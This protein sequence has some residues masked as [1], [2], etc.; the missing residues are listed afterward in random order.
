MTEGTGVQPVKKRARP[1]ARL[2][3]GLAMGLFLGVFATL[4]VL[5]I[6]VDVLTSPRNIQMLVVPTT[7]TALEGDRRIIGIVEERSGLFRRH[8]GYY[9]YAGCEEDMGYG[10]FVDL[11]FGIPSP[12][13]IKDA[14]AESG[15]IRVRFDS[16]HELVIPPKSLNCWR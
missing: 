10:H 6:D 3:L 9:V 1:N 14:V 11:D 12:P 13:V 7:G 4:T 8:Q 15:G 2:V 5:F 16:G